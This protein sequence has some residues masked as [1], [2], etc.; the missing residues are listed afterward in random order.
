MS[1]LKCLSQSVSELL[2]LQFRLFS[3][4]SL[5]PAKL[6]GLN[7][8]S[9]IDKTK[10]SIYHIMILMFLSVCIDSCVCLCLPLQWKSFF[11]NTFQNNVKNSLKY[12]N[13]PQVEGTWES[14]WQTGELPWRHVDDH[15]IHVPS[16]H[17]NKS[18]EH[19]VPANVINFHKFGFKLH[20]P[21][22][23]KMKGGQKASLNI[24]F[25]WLRTGVYI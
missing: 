14:S 8:S 2:S 25:Y 1:P 18:P 24:F 23:N 16:A 20:H 10:Q 11:W 7:Q 19:V 5:A 9:W 21:E 22:R 6:P 4:Q 17:W 3:G 13:W 12:L 15:G